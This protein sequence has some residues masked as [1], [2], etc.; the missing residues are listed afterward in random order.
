M[1]VTKAVTIVKPVSEVNKSI[2]GY[3]LQ[4]RF[5]L[6]SRRTPKRKWRTIISHRFVDSGESKKYERASDQFC[7]AWDSL[8]AAGMLY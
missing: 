4:L 7:E 5:D 3:I 2:A 6:H 1:V 8:K